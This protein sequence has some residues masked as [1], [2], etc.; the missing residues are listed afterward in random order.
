MIVKIIGIICVLGTSIG[1]G[2][3]FIQRDKDRLHLIKEMKKMLLLWRGSIRQSNETIPEVLENISG[4]LDKRLETLLK[5]IAIK[6]KKMN[7]ENLNNIWIDEVENVFHNSSLLD[8]DVDL[9]KKVGDVIGFLDKQL[10]I[11]NMDS[12]KIEID[13][14]IYKIKSEIDEKH[15]IYRIL[16]IMGG[17]FLIIILV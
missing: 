11:E 14:K 4:K 6:M 15:R 13:E 9:L 10:Q 1:I 12:F 16:S 5:N 3:Y 7:G 2:T 8:E 17:L